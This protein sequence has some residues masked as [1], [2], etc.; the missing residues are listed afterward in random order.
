MCHKLGSLGGEFSGKE[1]QNV[2]QE[3]PVGSTPTEGRESLG[4]LAGPTTAVANLMGSCEARMALQ[5]CPRLTK[6]P[7]L[8]TLVS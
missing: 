7:A 6:W 1:P 2:D 5:S 3:V 8:Y 4:C